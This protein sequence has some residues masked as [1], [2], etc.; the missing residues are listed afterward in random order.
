MA[1]WRAKWLLELG[2]P[3]WVP[4]GFCGP[5]T[6]PSSDPVHICARGPTRTARLNTASTYLETNPTTPWHLRAMRLLELRAHRHGNVLLGAN[7]RTQWTPFFRKVH[8][9]NG[10]YRPCSH[11]LLDLLLLVAVLRNVCV[12]RIL[13]LLCTCKA[14]Q[15]LEAVIMCI[16]WC[17]VLSGRL[18]A[19]CCRRP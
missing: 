1:K 8:R 5:R 13:L 10:R 16:A 17:T 15:K 6:A 12:D 11:Q 14:V 7:P 18:S 3:R 9:K 4:V 2:S 19:P